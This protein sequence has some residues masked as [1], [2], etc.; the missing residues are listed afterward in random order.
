MIILSWIP[1]SLV[2]DTLLMRNTRILLYMWLAPTFRKAHVEYSN[3]LYKEQNYQTC[4][5]FLMTD[6]TKGYGY[7]YGYGQTVKQ[8]HGTKVI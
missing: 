5:C 6:S 2:T 4:V 1:V 8:N 7:G 3:S